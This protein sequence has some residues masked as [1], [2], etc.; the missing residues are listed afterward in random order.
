MVIGKEQAEQVFNRYAWERRDS[1]ARRD[2]EGIA[3]VETGPLLAESQASIDLLKARAGYAGWVDSFGR[4]E[5]FIPAE[6]D[7]QGY[8]RSFVVT[9]REFAG[10][11]QNRSSAV[12]YFVQDAPGGE[13][14][15]TAMSWVNDRAAAPHPARTNEIGGFQLRDKEIAP[16]VRDAAGAVTLSPTAAADREV[17]GRYAKYMSFSVPDGKPE[18]EHFVPGELTGGVVGAYNA[19]GEKLKLVDKWLSLEAAGGELPVVRLADGKSL[20]T[21]TFVR[22]DFW[23]ARN[24][25]FKYGSSSMGDVGAMIGGMDT[26]WRASTVRRSVTVSFEVPA[27]GGPADVVGSNALRA[28]VLSAEGVPR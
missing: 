24:A 23:N 9:S 12:H 19:H 1:V 22:T 5:F 10:T 16:L 4:P 8:P 7:Q 2:R 18:S 11:E 27:G 25:K 21:C 20:V 3:K 26:W 15:A 28:P 14:K 17:C 13:W 6:K